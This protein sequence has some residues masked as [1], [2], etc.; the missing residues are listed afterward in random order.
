MWV[1][2]DWQYACI[3]HP[4]FDMHR[5]YEDWSDEAVEK[6]L[7]YWTEFGTME[8]LKQVLPI[9][10]TMA[11]LL[12]AWSI[13]E[14]LEACCPGASPALLSFLIDCLAMSMC[15]LENL[16]LNLDCSMGENDKSESV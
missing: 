10:C 11:W 6:Y 2:Y 14:C 15:R 5:I 12:K 3:S 13:I 16:G 7:G 8:K 4:F 9:A 1:L